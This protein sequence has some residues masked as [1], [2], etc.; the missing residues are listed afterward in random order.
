M[1]KKQNIIKGRFGEEAS[2][3]YLK[4]KRYKILD[5]NFR[6]KIGEVDIVA[7]DKST[8]VFIEVKSRQSNQYGYPSEA[9][10]YHKQRKISKVALYYLQS[11]KLFDYDYNIRFDVIEILDY[12]ENVKINHIVNAFE[13]AL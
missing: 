13:L 6:C 7:R 5:I 2:V 11:K 10:N 1:S 9:V 4:R 8:I 3:E 12:L